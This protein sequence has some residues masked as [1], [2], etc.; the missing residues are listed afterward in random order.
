MKKDKNGIGAKLLE[1]L[2]EL[3]LALVCFG[4]G[5]LVVSL[6]GVNLDSANMDAELVIL[7]GIVVFVVIFGIV[8][9]LVQL[10][11]KIIRK[12]K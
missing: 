4:I 12:R 3:A 2:I 5:A 1:G 11:K 8:F 7:L 6:F 10:L 9:A